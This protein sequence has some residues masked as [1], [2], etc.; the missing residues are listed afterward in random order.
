MEY[1]P[2]QVT[3]YSSSRFWMAEIPQKSKIVCLY[4][5]YRNKALRVFLIIHACEHVQ[6]RSY[7][8]ARIDKFGY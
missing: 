3:V 5:F 2:P 4:Y 8:P 6:P 1:H 7:M